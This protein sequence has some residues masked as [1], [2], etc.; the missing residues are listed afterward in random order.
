MKK[1]EIEQQCGTCKGTGLYTGLAERDG[2]AVVCMHCKGTGKTIF[3]HSYEDFT[4]KKVPN[5]NFPIERV[6][7]SN[8]GIVIG[9]GM[10]RLEHFGGI[11]YKDWADEKPFPKGSEMR[12]FVCPAWWYQSVDY[13]KKP[14]WDECI[15][16]GAF[17]QCSRFTNKAT[18]WLKWNEEHK[19]DR[20]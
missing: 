12:R 16:V 7:Q 14:K 2:A 17:S 11:P 3:T 18:C 9:K 19:N 15:G 20:S 6:F 13:T 5:E 1:I 10:H 8:P 4:G